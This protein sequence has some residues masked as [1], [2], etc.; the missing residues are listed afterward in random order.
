MHDTR[1]TDVGLERLK[2]LRQL[3]W[4]SLGGTKVTEQGIKKFQ[5]A[6]P[7]CQIVLD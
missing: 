6:L 2:G 1:I 7:S 4:L 3:Q 5:Q